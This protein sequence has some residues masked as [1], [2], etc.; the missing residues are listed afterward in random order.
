M[1]AVAFDIDGTLTSSPFDP[2]RLRSA[3]PNLKLIRTLK[4]LRRAGT[5]IILVTARPEQYRDDTT[6]WLEMQGISYDSLRMRR[7]GDN[8]PDH[9]LRAEQVEGASVLFDD[10]AENCGEA[11]IRC[12]RVGP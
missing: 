8:R 11:P 3:K 4:M 5:K 12:V 2:N 6:S 1:L 10:K 9:V 7:R